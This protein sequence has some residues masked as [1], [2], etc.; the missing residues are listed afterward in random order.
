MPR[1]LLGSLALCVLAVACGGAG[2]GEPV[3]GSDAMAPPQATD[4]LEEVPDFTI[5]TL[6]G[7]TFTLSDGELPT[8]LNFWAPW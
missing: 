3:A 5:A 2:S 8:V 1:L 7:D 6:G 4:E